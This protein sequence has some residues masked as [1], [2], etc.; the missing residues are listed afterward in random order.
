LTFSLAFVRV[1]RADDFPG[2]NTRRFQAPIDANGSLYLEPTPTP[3]PGLWNAAAWFVYSLRPDVLRDVNGAAVA[4]LVSHQLSTDLVGSVGIGQKIA[5][6]L[7]LPVLLYQTG[8]DNAVSRTVATNPPATTALGDLG[9]VGKM[10][11]VGYGEH[12]GFG[13]SA[14]LR[15]N[16][17]TGNRASYMSDGMT[18]GEFRLLGEY[19]IIA[20]AVQATLGMKFRTEAREVIN[21]TYQNEIP[22]GA[23]IVVRPQIFGWDPKG[24]FTWVAEVHGATPLLGENAVGN[25]PASWA[26]VGL[27]SRMAVGDLSFLLGVETSLT[28]H[29][30]GGAPLQVVAGAQWTPR[31]HDVDKDGVK[32]DVDQCPELAED[33]DGVQDADGCPDLEDH[34]DDGVPDG[35]DQCPNDKEDQDGYEDADGCPDPDNDEDGISDE[36]DACPNQEG[37]VYEDPTIKGCPDTDEDGKVDKLDKCPGKPE[38]FDG[39]QDADGCPELDND[40]DEVPDADDACPNVPAGEAPGW[41]LGCPLIDRDGDTIEDAADKCP[42]EPEVFNGVTDEDGCPDAGGRL[43][44]TVRETGKDVALVFARPMKFKGSRE[45]PELEPASLV[46]LRALSLE[47]N[48]HP[49]WMIAIGVRPKTESAFDQQAA[50]A[51]AFASVDAV[52]GFALRDAVA[53]TVGWKAVAT[54]PGAWGNGFGVLVF[55]PGDPATSAPAGAPPAKPAAPPAP[56]APAAPPTVIDADAPETAA[57]QGASGAPP[58]A[59]PPAS[60]APPK[61]PEAPKP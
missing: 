10:N 5:V 23:A 3:G 58:A 19:K 45:A 28:P 33:R 26:M 29:T 15:V 12:G 24:R 47:V 25:R 35:D 18:T 46:T 34:D 40:E 61:A 6:A 30:W 14:L 27:S 55:T 22:W 2:V 11:V 1:A 57:P 17:P 53:E 16:A 51:Q 7:D 39:Y 32:D 38:D 20:L 13:L 49:T 8:E 37:E 48:K 21:R 43:L 9:I 31:S 41:R 60:G 56:A 50:L 42:D 4:N 52:R 44:V 36:Q 59:P 54:Q